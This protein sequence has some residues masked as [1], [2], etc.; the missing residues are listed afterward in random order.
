MYLAY[1]SQGSGEYL[2]VLRE[3]AEP[4]LAQ[5]RTGKLS[6]QQALDLMRDNK[7][8][9]AIVRTLKRTLVGS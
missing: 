2:A 4:Y 3:G 8:H 7:E 1:A 5:V 6:T 9:L